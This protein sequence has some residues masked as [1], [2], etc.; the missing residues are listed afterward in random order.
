MAPEAPAAAD[1][2]QR[3]VAGDEEERATDHVRRPDEAI[4]GGR[5]EFG[6]ERVDQVDREDQGAGEEDDG[7]QPLQ[8]ARFARP[9]APAGR[10]R[11]RV[12]AAR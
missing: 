9:P 1:L 10:S 12:A 5:A 8:A 4:L 3:Q 6:D 11:V 2:D 7:A